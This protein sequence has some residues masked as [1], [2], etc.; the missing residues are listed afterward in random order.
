MDSR[1]ELFDLLGPELLLPSGV[2]CATEALLKP[3]VCDVVGFY[4]SASYCP[5]CKAFNPSLVDAYPDLVT[6]KKCQIILV[7]ND[8]TEEAFH[9]YLGVG[10]G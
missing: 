6:H 1:A 7:S 3:D 4:F 2:S 9:L 10:T 8:R 5:S